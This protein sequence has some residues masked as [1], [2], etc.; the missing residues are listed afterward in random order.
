MR[1]DIVFTLSGPDR[2][3]IVEEVTGVLLGLGGNV[4]TGRMARLGGEFAIIMLVS[5]PDER[6]ADIESAFE[7]LAAQGYRVTAARA[8]RAAAEQQQ[9]RPYRVELEGADHEGIVHEI[10]LGL[11]QRGINIESAETGTTRASESGAPL[12]WM[13]AL[14]AVPESLDEDHWIPELIDAG[15]ELNVDITVTRAAEV[16]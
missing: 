4:D 14:V 11:S 5:L 12:F 9:T 7:H 15:D 16:R 2:V 6:G 10:A 3:G 13:E 1:T 8:K